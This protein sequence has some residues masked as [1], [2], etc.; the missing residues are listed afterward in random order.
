MLDKEMTYYEID[1]NNYLISNKINYNDEDYLLLVNEQDYTDLIVQRQTNNGLEP[2]TSKD[3]LD[4]VL[5]LMRDK[6]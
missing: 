5:Y 2:V 4:K 3:I 1:G 6:N